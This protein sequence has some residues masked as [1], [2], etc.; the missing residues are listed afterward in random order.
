MIDRMPDF[1]RIIRSK[2]IEINK[3]TNAVL[4]VDN[5]NMKEITGLVLKGNR[6]INNIREEADKLK[7][8]K[9]QAIKASSSEKE[10]EV[11]RNIEQCLEVLNSNKQEGKNIADNLK[12]KINTYKDELKQKSEELKEEEYGKC[13]IRVINNLN[14][15]YLN[16][17]K[18]ALSYSQNVEN[19]IKTAIQKKILRSAE[20]ILGKEL[21]EDQKKDFLENPEKLQQLYEN[22]LTHG[23]AHVKLRNMVSDLENR[24]KEILNLEKNVNQVN[25]LFLDLAL[26]VDQ[27]GEMIDNI[28]MNIKDARNF[29]EKGEKDIEKA[30]EY[31]DSARKVSKNLI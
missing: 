23:L 14:G 17:F 21:D 18:E 16:N 1:L 28:E 26:L 19:D 12:I 24:H 13:E 20:E 15:T 30:K 7:S 2:E 9:D 25:R 5:E 22:R 29:V 6:V 11:K 27:Q 10:N 4:A 3:K 31:Q 8:Y